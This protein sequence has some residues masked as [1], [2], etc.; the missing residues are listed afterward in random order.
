MRTQTICAV[1][2]ATVA[3]TLTSAGSCRQQQPADGTPPA[4]ESRSLAELLPHPPFA[5][6]GGATSTS[7]P[8]SIADLAERAL[9]SVVNIWTTKVVKLDRHAFGAPFEA[10]P[11]FRQFFGDRFFGPEEVPRERRERSLGSGVIVSA[12]GL[13]LTNNHVVEQADEIRVTLADH[14]ELTATLVGRDPKSD[15]AVL[16]LDG[17]KDLRPLAFGDS[18]RLRLGDVVLA[19]GN[20]FGVGQTVTM[21]IVSAKGRANLRIVDYEDFIQTDA[22][23]NPGNSGGALINMAG[24]LVGINTAILS[25]TGGSQGIGF[26]IPSNMAKPILDSLVQN[27]K[28]VRGWLGVGIQDLT[29]DLARAF[30]LGSNDGVLVSDVAAGSPAEKAGLRRGDVVQRVDGQTVGSSAQLRNLIASRA[31]GAKVRVELLRG[32]KAMSF[33]VSLGEAPEA[34]PAVTLDDT[35]GLLAGIAVREL[36]EVA[37][38]KYRIPKEVREGVVVTE[39]GPRSHAREV[40]L[41]AGDVILEI[42]R[43]RI[44]SAKRFAELSKAATDQV[45]LLVHRDG[46]TLY[47]LVKR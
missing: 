17:V 34:G 9:P 22:A 45:L 41:Q 44:D 10:D 12:D 24:E 40:G 43:S 35:R 29:S 37:R 7:T 5:Y 8:V 32:G 30:D 20:P 28:V 18:S 14:R 11:L 15:L 6:A 16:R 36:D 4:G 26:A 3:L 42:N 13:V 27:G 47:L 21:G 23:I 38:Q 2:L 46:S 25:R 1:V 33:D 19:I 31:P 39:V